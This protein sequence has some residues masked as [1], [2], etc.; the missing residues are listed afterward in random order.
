MAQAAPRSQAEGPAS[1]LLWE[2]PQR[3]TRQLRSYTSSSLL[4]AE[5]VGLPDLA[6]AR[7]SSGE[8]FTGE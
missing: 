1:L 2:V 4:V 5:C 7:A 3:L 8:F 6:L